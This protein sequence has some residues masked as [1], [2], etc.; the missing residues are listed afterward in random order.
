MAQGPDDPTGGANHYFNPALVQPS[1]ARSMTPT[2][3]FGGHAFY[4]DRPPQQRPP[5][6]SPASQ[7][8]LMAASRA[9]TSPT[10]GDMGLQAALN[11]YATREGN[12]VTPAPRPSD[13]LAPFKPGWNTPR[14]NADGSI[15]TEV[16]RTVQLPD[17]SWSNVPSLW[18]GRGSDVKDFG[19]MGDDQLGSFAQRYEQ[20]SGQQFPRYS[21]IPQAEAAAVSRS[22]NG[23]G[24][25]DPFSGDPLTPA[26]GNVVASYSTS[27]AFNGD[28]LTPSN[29]PVIATI[30]TRS[31]FGDDPGTPAPGRVVATYPTTGVGSPP[32][33]RVVKSVAMPALA[34]V[35]KPS[36]SSNVASERSEQSAARGPAP[37]PAAAIAATRQFTPEP[38][39]IE[40]GNPVA[41]NTFVPEPRYIE[42][43]N[44]D[45]L[46]PSPAIPIGFNPA[47]TTSPM[48]SG[49]L[50]RDAVA[51]KLEY[52]AALLNPVSTPVAAPMPRPRPAT[53]P[54]MAAAVPPPPPV[55]QRMPIMA[56]PQQPLRISVQGAQPIQRPMTVVDRYRS[57]G[58]SPSQAYDAAN[59]AARERAIANARDPA[60]A[61]R[62]NDRL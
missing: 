7:T 31:A 32:S 29:G 52:N 22:N 18:W 60:A 24:T 8:P 16:T 28:P 1:W 49:G 10:G 35:A 38:R 2:G 44:T 4:T 57:E 39:Y 48:Q 3:E 41:A 61:R 5:A 43:L 15:S 51:R 34:Q 37:A 6:P 55:A 21:S 50:S 20:R 26:P 54:L 47:A 12:R 53:P 17:G 27:P 11:A 56:A 14:Q 46:R 36:A 9:V 45:R 59:S 25:A 62:L 30:P 23:G 58:M 40:P 13:A 19:S 42:P 33:T